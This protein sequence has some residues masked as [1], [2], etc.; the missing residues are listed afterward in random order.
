MTSHNFRVGERVKF[1]GSYHSMQKNINKYKNQIFI[2][3]RRVNPSYLDCLKP[4]GESYTA[5][6]ESLEKIDQQPLLPFMLYGL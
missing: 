1:I 5:H 4:D 6:Y 3:I 2:I